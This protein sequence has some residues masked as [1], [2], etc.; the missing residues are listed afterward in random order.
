MPKSNGT[1]VAVKF[2]K[3]VTDALEA[4]CMRNNVPN[5]I[6]P[7]D[8]HST[9]VCS[10][11]RLKNV[12][13]LRDIHPGWIAT[14]IGFD[15]FDTRHEDGS[16]TKC[17]VLKIDC[18]EMYA[19]HNFFRQ[20]E[21]A[22]HDFPSYIPHITLSYDIGDYDISGIEDIRTVLPQIAIVSEYSEELKD[23]DRRK[24]DR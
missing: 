21:K 5:P 12:A 3:E 1:F 11:R 6:Q 19:R 20:F 7:S 4:Y 16:T 17:L 24:K 14:P 23:H 2:A 9:V 8:F 18:P 15:V 10:R 13:L 22:S